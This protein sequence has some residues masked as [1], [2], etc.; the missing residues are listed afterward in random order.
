MRPFSL[1]H[2]RFAPDV[3]ERTRSALLSS[4]LLDR[5]PLYGSF[6]ATR[7]FAAIFRHDG[8]AVLHERLP[9]LAFFVD[10]ILSKTELNA[11]WPWWARLTMR[12]PT[13]NAFYLN[14]LVVPQGAKVDRHV[15]ATLRGPS[16][17]AQALPARVSVLYLLVPPDMKGGQ[18]RL[19]A[20]ARH[21]GDV[22]P[23]EGSLLHFNG[24]LAHEVLPFESAD[25]KAVRLSIVCEQYAL[26]AEALSR[27]E[28]F[29]LQS[30]ASFAKHLED[31]ARKREEQ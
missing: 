29:Q 14:V 6:R 17:E 13:P 21:V 5:S 16:G 31:H 8:I 7:G 3:V 22:T 15:D 12:V 18:L 20:G 19:H 1:Q 28:P 25:P 10:H 24:A 26:T 2:R 30:K 9:D 23:R 4:P 27:L 11:L